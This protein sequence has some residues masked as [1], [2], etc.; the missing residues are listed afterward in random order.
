MS[1][2]GLDRPRAGMGTLARLRGGDCGS[3]GGEAR[4]FPGNPA[5]LHNV[6]IFPRKLGT[7]P[8]T[9]MPRAPQ[10]ADGIPRRGKQS[11][12]PLEAAGR[13]NL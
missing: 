8:R 11:G 4:L 13:R 6:A 7:V 3:H 10:E 9:P 2:S 1:L 12:G 5:I